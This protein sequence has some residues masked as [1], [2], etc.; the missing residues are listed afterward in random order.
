ME[1]WDVYDENRIPTGKTMI[2][3]EEIPEGGYHLVVH[4]CIFN[5]R[6]QMLIQKRQPFKSGFSGM[7]DVTV[8]GSA[9]SGDDSRNA[10]QRELEEE[11]GISLDFSGIQPQLSINWERGF[12]DVYLLEHDV[13][14]ASLSLQ[15]EEVEQVKWATEDEILALIE[16][17]EFIPY[18]PELIRLYFA[19]RK[20]YGSHA[21]L[22]R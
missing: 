9:V 12:D 14:E 2:R 10:A 15:Y 21:P 5:S 22:S 20:K 6:G 8:G 16:C 13:D 1:L 7:W 19:M 11:V 3:G 17:G 4:V 18:Y